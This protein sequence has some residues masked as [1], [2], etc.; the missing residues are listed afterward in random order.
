MKSPHKKKGIKEK[1]PNCLNPDP[2][3]KSLPNG[4]CGV[5]GGEGYIIWKETGIVIK[6]K[7]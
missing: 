1:C 2:A 7:P 3:I 6:M 5:C 4:K